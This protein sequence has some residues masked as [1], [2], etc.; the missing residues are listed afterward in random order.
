MKAK[1][2]A[3]TLLQFDWNGNPIQ[4]WSFKI[5]IANFDINPETNEIYVMTK[6]NFNIWKGQ[7]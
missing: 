5:D 3:P 6:N 4:R 2:Q 7:L 1:Q